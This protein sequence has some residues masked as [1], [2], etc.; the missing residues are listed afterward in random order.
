MGHKEQ[1]QQFVLALR[2][3]PNHLLTWEG[4]RTASLSVF[5]A[6][7]SIRTGEPVHLAGFE[8]SLL[9]PPA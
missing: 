1:L 9:E 3:E 7:E 8:A 4:A 2:G 5:A 6:Q